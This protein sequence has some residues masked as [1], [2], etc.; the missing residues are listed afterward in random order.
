MDTAIE[1]E[2]VHFVFKKEE[3]SSNNGSR[4]FFPADSRPGFSVEH[5]SVTN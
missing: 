1:I 4:S 3:K 2:K 5:L